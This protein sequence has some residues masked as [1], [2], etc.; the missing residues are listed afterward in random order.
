M[1]LL[2]HRESPSVSCRQYTCSIVNRRDRLSSDYALSWTSDKS[3]SGTVIEILEGDAIGQVLR[4]DST[5]NSNRYPTEQQ[6]EANKL[7]TEVLTP[8]CL[9]KHD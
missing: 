7:A 2:G 9:K 5:S 3:Y 1:S 8:C 6:I 4:Q